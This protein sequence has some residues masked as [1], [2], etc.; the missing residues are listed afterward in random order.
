ML[1]EVSKGF[2]LKIM[3]KSAVFWLEFLSKRFRPGLISGVTSTGKS[4]WK[5]CIRHAYMTM[6]E[7]IVLISIA[8]DI[9]PQ[10]GIWQEYYWNFLFDTLSPLTN[11]SQAQYNKCGWWSF[12]FLAKSLV[13][14]F[15]EAV[16]WFPDKK[17]TALCNTGQIHQQYLYAKI[18]GKTT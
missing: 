15:V 7:V 18:W 16:A 2:F 8:S 11:I 1:N 3:N 17:K 6:S 12:I 9:A 14:P 5:V 13:L 10:K 4:H